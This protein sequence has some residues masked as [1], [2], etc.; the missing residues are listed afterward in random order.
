MSECVKVSFR[1]RHDAYKVITRKWQE[2]EI[3]DIFPL[4]AYRCPKCNAWHLT[5]N[6][7]RTRYR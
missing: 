2:R 1:T 4:G 7:P 5:S 3:T 6:I